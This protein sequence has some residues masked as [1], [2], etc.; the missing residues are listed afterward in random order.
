MAETTLYYYHFDAEQGGLNHSGE[1]QLRWILENA[2]E[3]RRVVW[4]QTGD[5][6]AVSHERMADVQLAVADIVGDDK[7]P[8]I[9]LRVT[10]PY[11]RPAQE[12][13]R[14]RNTEIATMPEPR[15]QYQTLPT[16]GG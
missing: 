13:D 7:T 3:E 10:T 15:V 11:G 5:K 8:P 6:R 14:I 16:G 2:P 12:I 1:M 9:M 4:V